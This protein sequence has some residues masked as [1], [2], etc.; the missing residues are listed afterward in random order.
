[1][2]PGV[3]RP[4]GGQL[5]ALREA[6]GFT[7]EE[8]ATIAGLSVHAVGAL[9][10][11]QRR[12]PHVETVRALS[13]ALD[14]TAGAR[15]ALMAS[16]RPA[17]RE[18]AVDEPGPASLPRPL[19]ALLGR[20]REVKVLRQWLA[21]PATRLITL[22]GP[23]GAGKT[24]LALELAR[25]NAVESACDVRFIELASVRN[26][27]LVATAIADAFGVRSITVVDLPGRL[28]LAC[29]TPTLLVLDNFEHLMAAAPLVTELLQSVAALRVLATSRAP[30]RVRGEREFPMGPLA[31][32]VDGVRTSLADLARA[33]AVRLFVERVRDVE[34]DFRLTS[35]NGPSVAAICRRLDGLPLALELAAP[36]IKVLTAEGL[37]RRLEQGVLLAAIGPR[38]LPERQQTMTATIA[39]SYRLLDPD[40]QRA[41][42]R[43]GALPGLF[44][45]DAAA[46]V[47]AG[48]DGAIDR[49]ERALAAAASLIEKSLLIRAPTSGVVTC[50]LYYMLEI[51]R[52]FAASELSAAGERDDALA[53]VARY[54]LAEAASAAAGLVGPTQVNWLNRVREDLQIHRGALGWLI[55]RGRGG[56]ASRIASSLIVFWAVRTCATE[57]LWWF[58]Q[59]L[60][61]PEIPPADEA[62]ALRGAAL[63]LYTQGKLERAR[64]A[65]ERAH[66][67]ALTVGD[68]VGVAQADN[69]L[70][71]VE[72]AMGHFD[73]AQD[74]FTQG[75]AAFRRLGA[76]WGVGNSLTGMAA[77]ALAT[78][79]TERAEG[80][81]EE[82]MSALRSGGPWFLSLALNVRAI[83]AVRRGDAIGAIVVVRE[84]LAHIRELQDTFAFVYALVPL[85]AAAV[86][87]GDDEWAAQILGTR[88]GITVRTGA[89][90]V[91][92]SV[93]DFGDRAERH[94]RAR[95]S[96]DRWS[97]AYA[98]GRAT[99]IDAL[100]ET[101]DAVVATGTRL[102]GR[103]LSSMRG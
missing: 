73:A 88:A 18:A 43:L 77:A 4:F 56:D 87:R 83:L 19:T 85:A 46:A 70:G 65:L 79:E 52:A 33:P 13:A 42:R 29:V 41:F 35:A 5:K 97:R 103:A 40:E 82:A 91:D 64:A 37:L 17:G 61:L 39:W 36:W 14:L 74:R 3:P 75:V 6:A 94:V 62:R 26:A 90:V 59:I 81:I 93:D 22:T 66:A 30:L 2:K 92:R 7:Q 101:I 28:Q 78:G 96:P 98:A 71:H 99:S 23:G 20:D 9:E 72:H 1:M 27:T 16:A 67:L 100:L 68:L 84:S 50:P 8:L 12:R 80:L 31:L 63:M 76:P 60:S 21:D 44:P 53:G 34:P 49:N 45:I 51:V 57:G 95:L 89:T 69:L 25:A 38:D 54:C 10:R 55:E 47:L 11:G 86:L 48:A 102:H 15:D 58:E 24:R 32:E